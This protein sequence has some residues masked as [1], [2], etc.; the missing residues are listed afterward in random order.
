[1][2]SGRLGWYALGNVGMLPNSQVPFRS[3]A[4]NAASSPIQ[5]TILL[6]WR[7]KCRVRCAT[8]NCYLLPI[9]Q[10]NRVM[11]TVAKLDFRD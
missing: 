3:N 6:T 2:V 1:M 4:E 9:R 11:D 5:E 8:V 7:K 10:E